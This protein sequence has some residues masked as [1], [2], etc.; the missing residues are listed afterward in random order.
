KTESLFSLD[1]L[2]VLFSF[3]RAIC[4]RRFFEATFISYHFQIN[5]STTFSLV[6]NVLKLFLVAA[7][8]G[9]LN[10]I[11]S[12]QPIRQQFPH[13]NYR[14]FGSFNLLWYTK[15]VGPCLT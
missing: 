11:A 4:L 8:F 14:K 9:D 10:N 5:L 13:G 2:V 15:A 12:L 3:Q 1:I 7:E 6:F